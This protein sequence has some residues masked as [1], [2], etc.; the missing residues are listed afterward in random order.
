MQPERVVLARLTPG[1][2]RFERRIE[3]AFNNKAI[4]NKRLSVV[5]LPS[6]IPKQHQFLPHCSHINWQ[7]APFI[8]QEQTQSHHID[9]NEAVGNEAV[10][11]ALGF[12]TLANTLLIESKDLK[13]WSPRVLACDSV[14]M[15]SSGSSVAKV[16]AAAAWPQAL[17]VFIA[18]T[19]A[20]YVA[21][22]KDLKAPSG[23]HLWVDRMQ[24][25]CLGR[26]TGL[27]VQWR[28]LISSTF[29]LLP[30]NFYHLQLPKKKWQFVTLLTPGRGKALYKDK[31][32][33][34]LVQ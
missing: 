20:H 29:E 24:Q 13:T 6:R 11:K 27:L 3:S 15:E 33:S 30:S 23:V 14:T 19:D 5:V 1:R 12:C 10:L 22:W 7:C 21:S 34:F 31:S 4:K 32:G 28:P 16:S 18:I 2:G 9:N 8:L 17:P 25:A 26:R